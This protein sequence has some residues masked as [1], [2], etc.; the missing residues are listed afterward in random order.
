MA[1]RIGEAPERAKKHRKSESS[2]RTTLTPPKLEGFVQ[3][4]G[5]VVTETQRRVNLIVSDAFD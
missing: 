1:G 2:D 3:R 5:L 4:R